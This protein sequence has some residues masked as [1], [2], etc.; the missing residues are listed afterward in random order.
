M[1]GRGTRRIPGHHLGAIARAPA[2]GHAT[3]VSG[4]FLALGDSYTIGEGVDA[5]ERWPA[6]L[7]AILRERGHDLGEPRIIARTG[8]TTGELAEAIDGAELA[9]RYALVS[10]L[11]GVNNQY[12]GLPLD[13]YRSEFGALLET[14]T[15]LA[16][17]DARRVIVLSIPD[18]GVTPFAEGRNRERVAAEIDA[19]NAANLLETLE[20]G[21]SYVD[22]TPTSRR[23]KTEPALIAGDGLHPSGA[24]YR[25]WAEL[26][27]AAVDVRP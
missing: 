3:R 20:R 15:A 5:A 14:A 17:G 6:Q 22:V 7:A 26:A 11:A 8:W 21:A 13:E 23:A 19:F 16:G 27:L 12:R 24:M 9:G 10:L 4:G 1:I 2:E 25:L 18:W